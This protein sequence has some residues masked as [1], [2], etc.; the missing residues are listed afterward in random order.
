MSF[1]TTVSNAKN[2]NADILEVDLFCM[3]ISTL[4][5]L[6]LSNEEHKPN[7]KTKAHIFSSYFDLAIIKIVCINKNYC[8]ASYCGGTLLF[9]KISTKNTQR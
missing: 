1:Q 7:P 5:T 2:I 9:P 8:S 3:V 4:L 6:Y